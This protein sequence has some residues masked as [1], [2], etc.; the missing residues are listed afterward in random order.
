MT[1]LWNQR[2][3]TIFRFVLITMLL[4]SLMPVQLAQAANP[5]YKIFLPLISK[6][7]VG[8]SGRVTLNGIAAPGEKMWLCEKVNNPPITHACMQNTLTNSDGYYFF[9]ASILIPG[10]VYAT[11]FENSVYPYS[12]KLIA[13]FTKDL[14]AYV[15]D[16]NIV[17][18]TFDVAN[19][20]LTSPDSGATISLPHE[21]QWS[22]RSN[23]PTDSYKLYLYY[24]PSI[25]QSPTITFESPLLG[26]TNNY[27]MDVL[28]AGFTTNTVYHWT[29]KIISPDG[30][31]GLAYYQIPLSFSNGGS[32]LSQPSLPG[33]I[34]GEQYR[35]LLSNDIF[36]MV[37]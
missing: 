14:D 15:A 9:N 20:I 2:A 12:S 4:V 33:R 5:P 32:S 3:R 21:F 6:L 31:Y 24:S 22:P 37:P 13:W 25:Y 26:Y 8:I 1:S 23:S 11:S 28:P 27:A 34:V 7:F 29:V 10:K 17:I 19:V 36:Y 18:E 30:S 16:T 35:N